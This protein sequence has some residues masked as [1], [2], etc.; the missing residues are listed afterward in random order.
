MSN[1]LTQEQLHAV[2]HYH[3]DTGAFT[4]RERD[5]GCF[6]IERL[7]K[8]FNARFAGNP[9]GSLE[10]TGYTTIKVHTIKFYAHRLVFLYITGRFPPQAVDHINHQRSDNRWVNLREATVTENQRNQTLARNNTSGYMGV[11]W[12]NGNKRWYARIM[13]DR[14]II[15]LGQFKEI[16]DAVATRKAAEVEY[17]YHENHGKL[18]NGTH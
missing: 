18:S 9:A 3:P 15:F 7:W 17:G 16:E 4:W 6:E 10:P 8:T 2:L 14:K 12:H 13:V 5:R 11:C 1:S